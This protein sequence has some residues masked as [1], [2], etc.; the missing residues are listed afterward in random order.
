MRSFCFRLVFSSGFHSKCRGKKLKEKKSS[1]YS[2]KLF[3]DTVF[4]KGA[5][6]FWLCVCI[7]VSLCVCVLGGCCG[8]HISIQLNNAF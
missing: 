7:R 6:P 8:E 3:T 4:V 5:G 2:K 1:C